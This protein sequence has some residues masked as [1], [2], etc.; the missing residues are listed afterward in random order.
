[1]AL[2][3]STTR[4]PCVS[5]TLPTPT[6]G[7]A[8]CPLSLLGQGEGHGADVDRELPIHVPLAG[9]LGDAE[10]GL[11]RLDLDFHHKLVARDH[12]PLPFDT[13]DRCEKEDRA[14]LSTLHLQAHDAR[15]LGERLDLHDL[16]GAWGWGG[17]EG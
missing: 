1:M 17:G 16:G 5:R 10:L 11:P 9:R 7:P 3:S 2:P 14:R 4:Y 6:A 12:R 15:E 13:V 8:L